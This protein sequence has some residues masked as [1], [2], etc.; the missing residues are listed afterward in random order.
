MEANGGP[1][2]TRG[3]RGWIRPVLFLVLAAVFWVLFLGQAEESVF[4]RVPILDEV[5]YLDRAAAWTRGPVPPPEPF[6]VSPLYPV[7]ISSVGGGGEAP[8][9]RV[10]PSER[11]RGVRVFQIISWFG[12]AVLL[13][14]IA[15]RYFGRQN[16]PGWRLEF[17]LWLPTILFALYRPAAVYTVSILLEL[18]LLFLMTAAIYLLIRIKDESKPRVILFLV[19]G[20]GA[21]I[22]LA[23]LLRG[24]A[25]LMAIPA[26]AVVVRRRE[27]RGARWL[28]PLLLLA[29]TA[30]ILTPA[31]IHNS[32]IA[33]RL[34]GPTHN[35]GV[36][37]YIG[38]G[39][40]AN[41][42]YVAVV[43][44]DWRR[45]PAG[46]VFL[47]E[48][49]GTSTPSLA[50]ADQ[51]WGREAFRNMAENAPRTFGL[52]LKKV[53]L[54]LQGW[55]IDQLTPLAGWRRAAPA[56]NWLPVPFALLVILG[57]A[58]VAGRWRDSNIQLVLG[59]A[60][61]LVAGQSVF[62]VVSR[63]R[64]ALVPLLCLLGAVGLAEIIRGNRKAVIGSFIAV[65]VTVPWGLG[66]TRDL[67]RAQAQA[68][69]ARRWAEI[70]MN[71]DTA[72]ELLKAE[73]LYREAL[74]GLSGTDG[75]PA[76]W[77][78]LA[79][80]LRERGERTEAAEILT[81]GAHSTTRNLEINKALLAIRLEEGNRDEALALS[82]AILD[83][84][85][86]DADTLHN[87]TV[88]LFET[89]GAAEAVNTARTLIAAHP[90][91]PRGYV[92]LGIIL[93]RQGDRS[94]A[95]AVF[96]EG[97]RVFPENPALKKNLE[98]LIR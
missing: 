36:N 39:P 51:I 30:A 20:I 82:R 47:G 6:F 55:E 42:F 94:G 75:G 40:E 48:T 1:S 7:L 90:R 54:H 27:S 92:D 86:R 8:D 43:P 76:P 73:A 62:F 32:S 87:R 63:Y 69:E 93:A 97:L 34:T 91:D 59:V 31:V 29:T 4:G 44:G 25:L 35:G 46:R 2:S 85:P 9:V 19:V 64:L 3:F 58:G 80:L 16:N 57:A 61:V 68:N 12:V 56:L 26:M 52:W 83:G 49:M 60:G 84:H 10:F 79:S 74:A 41:G 70:G 13:R 72:A 24:T 17:F 67:W 81:K 38:N 5:Y 15:G 33:G 53:W 37:L 11:L 89:G 88:L 45:D 50:D 77:L 96:E 65:L 21:T 98:I 78:G 23:G 71:T 66:D 18:P 22:G 28:H 95:R 14:L